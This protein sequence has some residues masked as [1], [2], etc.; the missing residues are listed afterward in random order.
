MSLPCPIVDLIPQKGKMSLAQTL[1]KSRKDDGESTAIL[2][3]NIFIDDHQ[4][5]SNTALI[6]YLNQLNAAISGY[7]SRYHNEP[8]RKGLFVGLQDVEFFQTVRLGDSFTIKAFVTEEV[9]QVTFVQGTIH[10]DQEKI[11]EL[12]TKVYEFDGNSQFE[13]ITNSTQPNTAI[14]SIP[15]NNDPP[16]SYLS[17]AMQRKLYS[18]L[19]GLKIDDDLITFGIACPEDFDA[20]D[21]HF[22]ENP[23]LPGIILLEIGKLALQLF[24]KAPVMVQ[25]L[26]KMKIGGVVLPNQPVSC[27]VKIDRQDGSLFWFTA[28]FKTE[29]DREISRFNGNCIKE[30]GH[31]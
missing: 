15:F 23:I 8:V 26:K 3:G 13:F 27:T 5:L 4:Q 18:Y 1:V 2:S 10:R 14:N 12:V 24:I 21:G 31:V 7:N 11:A 29:G 19:H 6:E 20:F 9:G 22:P 17:S 16:P 25:T 30:E 28:I